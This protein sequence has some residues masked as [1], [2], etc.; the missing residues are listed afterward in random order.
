MSEPAGSPATPLPTPPPPAAPVGVVAVAPPPAAPAPSRAGRDLP[1]AIVVGVGLAALVLVALFVVKEL[2][3]VVVMAAVA[4]GLVEISTAVRRVGVRLSPTPLIIAAAMV[5]TSAYVWGPTGLL[6]GAGLAALMCLLWVS[7]QGG[8]ASSRSTALFAVCYLPG[9]AGFALLMVRETDGLQRVLLLIA[10]AVANDVGG[11]ATGVWWGKH[12]IAASL[13]PKKSWEG[14]LGS[15]VACVA[16]AMGL[17]LWWW[18]VSWWQPLIVGPVVMLA[19]TV[20][21]FAESTIKRDLGVK[22]M[23]SLLPGHGGILDR[24]DSLLAAAPVTYLLLVTLGVG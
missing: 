4:L 1:R 7:R 16:V 21:D 24:L 14:A 9:L 22:D 17:M 23:S 19:A 20:G 5:L 12:P 2:F 13:S 8:A 6:V 15:L 11:Y 10:L 3:V 18:Q